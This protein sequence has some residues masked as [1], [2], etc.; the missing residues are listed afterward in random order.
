M[1]DH[2]ARLTC[3]YYSKSTFKI[4]TLVSSMKHILGVQNFNISQF[5]EILE[6]FSIKN[7]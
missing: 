7:F 2:Q 5:Y 3:T 1:E 4:L 6:H